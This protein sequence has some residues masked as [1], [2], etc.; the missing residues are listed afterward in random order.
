METAERIDP[1]V[2]A[3]E[4][5]FLGACKAF[6]RYGAPRDPANYAL[7][8]LICSELGAKKSAQ[9]KRFE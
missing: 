8:K 1:Q 4:K 9:R 3:R 5:D 2:L 7:Y 6:V